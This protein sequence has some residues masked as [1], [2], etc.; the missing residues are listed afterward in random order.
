MPISSQWTLFENDSLVN[1]KR[2]ITANQIQMMSF[3]NFMNICDFC[4]FRRTIKILVSSAGY[5][6]CFAL[7]ISD[8]FPHN[9]T[10]SQCY[11]IP[12]LIH[13]C[14]AMLFVKQQ[15][16]AHYISMEYDYDEIEIAPD[17]I[18]NINTAKSTRISYSIIMFLVFLLCCVSMVLCCIVW[19]NDR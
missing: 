17:T 1:Q 5:F 11:E 7:L 13:H 2:N 19:M 8:F 6:I 4:L 10:F 3:F 9:K 16:Y 14:W 15:C 18:N 12:L